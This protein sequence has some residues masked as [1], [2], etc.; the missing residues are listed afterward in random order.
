[1]NNKKYNNTRI[2]SKVCPSCKRSEKIRKHCLV[3]GKLCCSECSNDG[4]CLDCYTEINQKQSF[5]DY[6]NEVAKV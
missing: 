4:M 5:D 6:F 3:C 1:M 2:K